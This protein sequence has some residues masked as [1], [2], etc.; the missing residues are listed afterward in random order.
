MP[1]AAESKS[2]VAPCAIGDGGALI[3]VETAA[4]DL[5]P[6]EV[7]DIATDARWVT[8]TGAAIDASNAPDPAPLENALMLLVLAEMTG[9]AAACLEQ[10]VAYVRDRK[11][12]GK[13]VGANQAVKHMAADAA[14]RWRA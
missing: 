14:M 2:I 4:A 7:L 6:A 10:T 3:A 5:A 13:P 9:S 8:V 11:Q 12:F 1:F